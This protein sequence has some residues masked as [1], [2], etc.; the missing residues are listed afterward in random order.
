MFATVTC[1]TG[2]SL[3]L[4]LILAAAKSPHPFV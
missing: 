2:F 4:Y 1:E 3:E